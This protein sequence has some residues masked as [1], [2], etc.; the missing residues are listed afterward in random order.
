M[1]NLNKSGIYGIWNTHSGKVY[2]GSTRS[3]QGFAY[4][5]I[6]HKSKLKSR[7]HHSRHLQSAWNKYPSTAFEFRVIEE[8]DDAA[9]VD[10]ENFWMDY[11]Q[12]R[13][14]D[15]GYNSDVAGCQFSKE[16]REK[17]R[18][19]ILGRKHTEEEKIKM[20]AGHV[21][22]IITDSERESPRALAVG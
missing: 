1:S 11:Y 3:S 13:D 22:R 17:I 14:R 19:G 16:H 4:R 6:V 15:H 12:S 21:G 10:R 7:T 9:L 2:V 20:R 8:C 5:W 18:L